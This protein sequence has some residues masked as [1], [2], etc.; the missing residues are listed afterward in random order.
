MSTPNS[1]NATLAPKNIVWFQKVIASTVVYSGGAI[2]QFEPL[3]GNQGVRGFNPDDEVEAKIIADLRVL[4]AANKGGVVAITAETAEELKKNH[5][6]QP[7][8][9]K[10]GADVLRA[11]GKAF[12]PEI[13]P[14]ALGV[15]ASPPSGGAAPPV[16]PSMTGIPSPEQLFPDAVKALESVAGEVALDAPAP[17]PVRKQSELE[18]AKKQSRKAKGPPA[19]ATEGVA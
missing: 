10:S 16:A 18:G 8:G 5:P 3:S 17:P 2:V 6:P 4:V 15:A 12:R 13:K 11:A 14:P 19:L 9:T 7:S 1:D